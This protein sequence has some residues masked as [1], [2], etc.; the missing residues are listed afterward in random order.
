VYRDPK[1]HE[2]PPHLEAHSELCPKKKG[3]K[4]VFNFEALTH[5]YQH[6]ILSGLYQTPELLEKKLKVLHLGTGAGTMP[7]FLR[8]QLGERLEKLVTVEISEQMEKVAKKFF[9]FVPD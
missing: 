2:I 6:A 3:K 8:H 5:E 1:K 9:G 4:A 7:M